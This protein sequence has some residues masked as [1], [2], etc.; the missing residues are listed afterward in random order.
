MK[1]AKF[2][3]YTLCN[4]SAEKWHMTFMQLSLIPA[5]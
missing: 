5:T 3:E 4:L 1:K 2:Y